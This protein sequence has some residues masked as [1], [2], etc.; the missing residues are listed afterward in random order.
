VRSVRRGVWAGLGGA[1]VMA[2]V[3]TAWLLPHAA[4]TAE[5]QPETGAPAEEDTAKDASDRAKPGDGDYQRVVNVAAGVVTLSA[6]VLGV[7]G[8]TGGVAVALLRNAPEAVATASLAAGVAVLLGVASAFISSDLTGRGHLRPIRVITGLTAL[9]VVAALVT[10]GLAFTSGAPTLTAQVLWWL[11]LAGIG[12][13]A[14]GGAIVV[15]VKGRDYRLKTLA[16]LTSLAVFGVSVLCVVV[17]A[18]GVTRTASRPAV[19]VTL[20]FKP[21]ATSAATTTAR[22]AAAPA[23][24][25]PQGSFVLHVTV[26]SLGMTSDERYLVAVDRADQP[27]NAT[28]VKEVYRTYV[29]PDAA[30]NVQYTFSMPLPADNAVPWLGVSATLQH[31]G[32]PPTDPRDHCG[33]EAGGSRPSGSTCA[34]VY[35]DPT[36]T[37]S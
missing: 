14:L 27:A 25:S 35:A 20:E 5:P 37:S 18:A 6:G 10:T 29:G 33:V 16:I 9:L 21:A 7:F 12:A 34:L 30:G 15:A 1:A 23:A 28:Q 17:L 2:A 36:L 4:P 11:F 24:T 19:S 26:K 13:L 22:S 8:I 32:E 3:L 31:A